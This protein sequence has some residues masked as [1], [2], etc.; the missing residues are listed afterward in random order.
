MPYLYKVLQNLH[1]ERLRRPQPYRLCDADTAAERDLDDP[2]DELGRTRVTPKLVTKAIEQLSHDDRTVI[3]R[4]QW[5][6]ELRDIRT[7]RPRRA[8]RASG[9]RRSAQ[10]LSR[11]NNSGK[12]A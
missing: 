5:L 9:P 1:R 8:A 11:Q 12:R 7:T 10:A 3:R 6:A 4:K 2:L